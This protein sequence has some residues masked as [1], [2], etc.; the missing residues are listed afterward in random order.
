[1]ADGVVVGSAIV[2]RIL[3]GAEPADVAALVAEFR[4]ALDDRWPAK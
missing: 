4:S 2:R 1:M 3:E